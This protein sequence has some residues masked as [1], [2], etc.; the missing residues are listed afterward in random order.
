MTLIKSVNCQRHF[1]LYNNAFHKHQG[2]GF[3]NMLF[4]SVKVENCYKMTLI[5][6]VNV[7]PTCTMT[8]YRVSI[9]RWMKLQTYN[10]TYKGPRFRLM[11]LSMSVMVNHQRRWR[12]WKASTIGNS[13]DDNLRYDAFGKCHL[14][15]ILTLKKHHL[16]TFSL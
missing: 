6:R 15:S 7:A 8:L 2:W 1:N 9:L 3:Q 13:Y 10:D 4:S 14:I 5:N 12:L 16:L 11:K